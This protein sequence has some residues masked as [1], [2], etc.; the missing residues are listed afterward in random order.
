MLDVAGASTADGAGV[1]QWAQNWGPNQGFRI[2]PVGG[3]YRIV[4][5]IMEKSAPAPAS[6]IRLDDRTQGLDSFLTS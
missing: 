1:Q 2:E 5:A 3:Y 4:S 6:R